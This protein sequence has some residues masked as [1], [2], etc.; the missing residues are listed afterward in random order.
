MAD[1][2]PKN[3]GD[4]DI[5]VDK[6][7]GL[8]RVLHCLADDVARGELDADGEWQAVAT[9]VAGDV[10]AQT[11]LLIE[12]YRREA[13]AVEP[14]KG[15]RLLAQVSRLHAERHSDIPSAIEAIVEALKLAPGCEEVQ[16]ETLRLASGEDDPRCAMEI[17]SKAAEAAPDA[18]I[19]VQQLALLQELKLDDRGRAAEHYGRVL[20]LEPLNMGAQE[21]LLRL[22]IGAKEW[23]QV[24]DR[25]A[26]LAALEPQQEMRDT[27]ELVAA[28]L[29]G[30]DTEGPLRTA[31][32]TEDQSLRQLALALVLSRTQTTE[33]WEEVVRKLGELAARDPDRASWLL[34][35]ASRLV[36]IQLGRVGEAAALAREALAHAPGDL[37][38]IDWLAEL[39]RKEARWDDLVLLLREKGQHLSADRARLEVH[40]TIAEILESRITQPEE[41]IA[42]LERALELEP[43]DIHALQHLGRLYGQHRRWHDLVRMHQ[44]EAE[45]SE[46]PVV[47]ATALYR[48]GRVLAEKMEQPEQ[49][50]ACLERA[51]EHAPSQMYA[52]PAGRLLAELYQQ[53]GESSKLLALH[54]R[55]LGQC[56]STDQRIGLLETIGAIEHRLR[57]HAAATATYTEILDLE[58]QHRASM[59]ALVEIHAAEERYPAMLSVLRG[60]VTFTGTPRQKAH[61]LLRMGHI[62]EDKTGDAP[63]ALAHFEEALFHDPGCMEAFVEAG[64]LLHSAR[65]WEDLRALYGRQI[66]LV[67]EPHDRA[68]LWFSI[69][70]IEEQLLNQPG[71]ALESYQ[72]ALE[73]DPTAWAPRRGMVRVAPRTEQPLQTD[74]L[75]RQIE[76]TSLTPQSR[77]AAMMRIAL[78]LGKDPASVECTRRLFG[79]VLDQVPDHPLAGL[80]SLS[81]ATTCEQWEQVVEQLPPL[82]ASLVALASLKQPARALELLRDLP[83]SELSPVVVRWLELLAAGT[84]DIKTQVAALQRRIEQ[85][86]DLGRRVAVRLRLARLAE[87][88]AE[89]E[90]DPVQAYLDLLAEQPGE[91]GA[92]QALE[93][94]ARER[95]DRELLLDVLARRAAAAQGRERAAALCTRGDLLRS[96]GDTD[97]A[98]H[99]WREALTVD[100]GC[101]AAY[102]ALKLALAERG[103]EEGLREV[104]EQGLESVEDP[105][106]QVGDLIRRADCRLSTG[107]WQGAMSDLDR[108]LEF[109]PAQPSAMRR[110]EAIL[111]EQGDYRGIVMR[112]RPAA[113]RTP[114]GQRRAQLYLTLTRICLEQLDSISDAERYVAAAVEA[115]P[116]N[117]AALLAAAA[118]R[119]RLD[120]PTEA[121]TLYRRVLMRDVEAGTLFEV[122]LAL[123]DIYLES[124]EDLVQAEEHLNAALQL[125]GGSLAA[126]RRLLRLAGQGRQGRLVEALQL[127]S[128]LSDDP[129]EKVKALLQLSKALPQQGAEPLEPLMRAL[130]LEPGNLECLTLAA[131]RLRERASWDELE[132]ILASGVEQIAPEHR[133]PLLLLRGEV[134][135]RHL[136]RTEEAREVLRGVLRG[137][138]RHDGA[139]ELMLETMVTDGLDKIEDHQEA[140]GLFRTILDKHPLLVDSIRALRTLADRA[141][142]EDLVCCAESCLV[143]LGEA[144]EEEVYFHRQRR[145]RLPGKAQRPLSGEEV[146][147]LTLPAQDHP[148]RQVMVLLGG[149]LGELAPSDLGHYGLDAAAT[150]Q[151]DSQ[152][153]VLQQ[154]AE[155]LGVD[156]YRTAL[157][158]GGASLGVV[159]PG[160]TPLLLLPEPFQRYTVPEQRFICGRLL[161]RVA[162][163]TESFDPARAEPLSL[164]SIELLLTALRRLEQPDF[165]A[166]VAPPA[167]LDDLVGRLG[168]V[169]PEAS[170]GEASRAAADA[171][172]AMQ[173]EDL[174]PWIRSTELAACR[175]GLICC[176]SVNAAASVIGQATREPVAEDLL[177]ELVR[178]TLCE[179]HEVL[180]REL[181]LVLQA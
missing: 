115:D 134:L 18:A 102:E 81:A 68:R 92:I 3:G 24:A 152:P 28:L 33:Q 126:A 131:S 143:L 121:L 114:S 22:Q 161:S 56:E 12:T 30:G 142:N 147:A 63:L 47:R 144:T 77:V 75:L 99:D 93:R 110:I 51:L 82:P 21:A 140:I 42:E 168:R 48:C 122:R 1:K 64:R 117:V 98:V 27:L 5:P 97:A 45:C 112:F 76:E 100:N 151:S 53:M 69:G 167:V 129:A 109:K 44:G 150:E 103:D 35:V 179:E 91:S 7:S 157:A 87:H 124:F 169:L 79:R 31:G 8:Q 67:Q 23:G 141:D 106:V 19:L 177:R 113:E 94:I 154:C 11:R 57:D 153:A 58:P 25:C 84:H 120:Q 20:E 164:R 32:R 119:V 166:E 26:T 29:V 74:E 9:P 90:L 135:S 43:T 54:R 40:L 174:S 125:D 88:R 89:A 34:L 78:R 111:R 14:T 116:D 80:L 41:A 155:M 101:R 107:N 163:R 4:S 71:A 159:E 15:A 2:T 180:R 70:W 137:D 86:T 178:F 38:V 96:H 175:G 123:F 36:G 130:E 118:L 136:Q 72:R 132:R 37:V 156:R 127:V 128:D 139:V 149:A 165:G 39:Y 108:V 104:L 162:A 49:A 60:L 46:D 13:G 17:L 66:E 10:F 50:V 59:E 146:M 105:E 138:P 6:M 181:G 176:G 62:I 52:G 73:E 65:R 160:E 95:D 55:Q 171:L 133:V 172:E 148:V 170:L 173:G 85:E 83:E 16:R 158:L 145:N 61:L